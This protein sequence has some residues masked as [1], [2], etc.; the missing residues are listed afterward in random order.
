MLTKSDKYRHI[1]FMADAVCNQR[2]CEPWNPSGA[3]RFVERV[4]MATRTPSRAELKQG[5]LIVNEALARLTRHG[6]V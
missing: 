6:A 5:A 3:Y 1:A 2:E 4:P